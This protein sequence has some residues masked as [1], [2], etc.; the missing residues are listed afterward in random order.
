MG[1]VLKKIHLHWVYEYAGWGL[2]RSSLGAL[3]NVQ[4]K[5]FIWRTFSKGFC[6]F[7]RTWVHSNRF[8][9]SLVFN[10]SKHN[11]HVIIQDLRAK[12]V[13]R[14]SV[15]DSKTPHLLAD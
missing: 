4:G 5:G 7:L 11:W 2:S 1:G 15:S 3:K 8:W 13:E 14:G 10:S 6:Y 9:R 12:L